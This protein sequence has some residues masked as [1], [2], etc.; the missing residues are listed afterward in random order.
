M[1]NEMLAA[2]PQVHAVDPF[3]LLEKQQ[4]RQ[5][6]W[7][8]QAEP[9][10][11]PAPYRYLKISGELAA[12]QKDRTKTVQAR[13]SR[14]RQKPTSLSVRAQRNPTLASGFR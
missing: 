5:I 1:I 14:W 6:T 10:R 9:S 4:P 12:V 7:L 3:A 13:Q 11:N 2:N 8:R